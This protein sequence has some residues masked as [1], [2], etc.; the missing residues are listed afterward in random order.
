MS[1]FVFYAPPSEIFHQKGHI[2]IGSGEAGGYGR[3]CLAI[4]GEDCGVLLTAGEAWKIARELI[5][6]AA[7]LTGNAWPDGGFS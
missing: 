1:E 2:L 4:P 5:D 6:Y 7:E 3:I